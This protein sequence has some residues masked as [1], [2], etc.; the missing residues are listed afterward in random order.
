MRQS[1]SLLCGILILV[2]YS[3]ESYAASE[4]K[5]F[6]IGEYSSTYKEVM[7]LA[8]LWKDAVLNKNFDLI[9]Q[10]VLPEN[11][12]YAKASLSNKNSRLY[13]F[14]Y[15]SEFVKQT[16]VKRK[17]VYDFLKTAKRIK[18]VLIGVEPISVFGITGYYY[19]ETKTK[20]KFPLSSMQKE[21]LWM[22]EYVECGFIKI[23]NEW[24][25][26]FEMQFENEDYNE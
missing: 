15:D 5:E 11:Y 19:D 1:F 16:N 25:F 2:I 3:A 9:L 23:D 21:K 14:L 12:E 8:I 17:S 26:S 10:N 18:I 22:M 20:F 13:L 6:V 7:P 4:Q 24:K